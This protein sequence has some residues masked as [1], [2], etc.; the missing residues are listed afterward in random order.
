MIRALK[1]V[2]AVIVVISAVIMV[3]VFTVAWAILLASA[4]AG[5]GIA[6][7]AFLV[8]CWIEDRLE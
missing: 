5:M 4:A 1:I 8:I 2:F 7:L 6:Y 3:F